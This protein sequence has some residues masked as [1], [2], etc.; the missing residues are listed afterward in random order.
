MSAIDFSFTHDLSEEERDQIDGLLRKKVTFAIQSLGNDIYHKLL[1]Y[2]LQQQR[3]FKGF[4][5][6][7]V[8]N[9]YRDS[10]EN[11]FRVVEGT[12]FDFAHFLG[13]NV[14]PIKETTIRLMSHDLDIVCAPLYVFDTG[15]KNIFVGMNKTEAVETEFRPKMAETGLEKVYA[16]MLKCCLVKRRVIDMFRQV[17]ESY[18]QWSP[19]LHEKFRAGTPDIIFFA[20]AN[21]LGFDV[22]M[23]WG[24][25]TPEHSQLVQ[26]DAEAIETYATHVVLS[27]LIGT[28]RERELMQT[29]SGRDQLADILRNSQVVGA[30]GPSAGCGVQDGGDAP[31]AAPTPVPEGVPGGASGGEAVG[32]S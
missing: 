30:P 26:L 31:A 11:L 19:L 14:A 1:I 25:E 17:K 16:G 10:I 27:F 5:L 4:N 8:M 13:P 21:A 24:C 28:E 22:W 29:E 32:S 9:P 15:T 20:K 7:L 12:N 2:L 23:D 3:A 6:A 18:T